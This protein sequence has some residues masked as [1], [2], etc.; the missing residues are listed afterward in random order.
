MIVLYGFKI[1]VCE[2][3]LVFKNC[4]YICYMYLFFIIKY[5]VF[6]S[7][8]NVLGYNVIV[9]IFDEFI[10]VKFDFLENVVVWLVFSNFCWLEVIW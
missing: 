10:I 6:I 5:K 8:S 1:M 4:C 7:V 9:I 3:D 2:K